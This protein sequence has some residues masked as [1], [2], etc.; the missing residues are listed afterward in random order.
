MMLFFVIVVAVMAS[1]GGYHYRTLAASQV[2][3]EQDPDSSEAI[4]VLNES[5]DNSASLTI[6]ELFP[7]AP[8]NDSRY[9]D[10][11]HSQHPSVLKE[12]ATLTQAPSQ[13]NEPSLQRHPRSADNRQPR[14]YPSTAMT[15]WQVADES[16]ETLDNDV[17][18][19]VAET[20]EALNQATDEL[21]PTSRDNLHN[22]RLQAAIDARRRT[23]DVQPRSPRSVALAAVSLEDD[24]RRLPAGE[25]HAVETAHHTESESVGRP[26]STDIHHVTETTEAVNEVAGFADHYQEPRNLKEAT[27]ILRDLGIRKYKLVSTDDGTTFQFSCAVTEIHNPRVRRRFMAAGDE[28]LTAVRLVLRQIEDWRAKQ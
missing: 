20:S 23:D 5:D 8:Q 14:R 13:N 21:R 9:A 3:H 19:F 2:P 4:V 11:P 7:D 12:P 16:A 27:Q 17:S 15:G 18:A 24:Q 26:I 6:D 22:S 10:E 25:I 1:L 28:P